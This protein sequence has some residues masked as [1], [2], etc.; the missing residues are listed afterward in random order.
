MQAK[1]KGH[2]RWTKNPAANLFIF[3]TELFFGRSRRHS[4]KI[5]QN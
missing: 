4:R 2:Q 5:F 3:L 1:K